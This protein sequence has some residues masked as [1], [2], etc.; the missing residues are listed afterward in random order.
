MGGLLGIDSRSEDIVSTG[1]VADSSFM[2]AKAD[3][4]VKVDANEN[5]LVVND[6]IGRRNSW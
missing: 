3:E 6:A 4:G 1:V 2:A 5:I